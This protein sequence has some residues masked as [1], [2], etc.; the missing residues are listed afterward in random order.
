M[1]GEGRSDSDRPGASREFSQQRHVS[2]GKER[3]GGK[4]GVGFSLKRKE[5]LYRVHLCKTKK[6]DR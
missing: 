3:G 5:D 2:T 6:R 4:G 1:G